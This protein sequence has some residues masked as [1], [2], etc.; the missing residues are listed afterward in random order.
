M[1]VAGGDNRDGLL[2]V[3]E[4]VTEQMVLAQQDAEQRELLAMLQAFARDRTGFLSFF[5]EADQ[6]VRDLVSGTADPGT[7]KRLVHTLK[8][9]A[10]MAS[11][12]VIVQLCHDAETEIES[13]SDQQALGIEALCTRWA[14]LADAFKALL[15]E[16]ARDTVWVQPQDLEELSEHVKGGLPG[17]QI[18][19]RLAAWHDEPV[20]LPLG[21]LAN[22]ARA[23]AGRLGKGDIAVDLA[24]SGLRLDPKRWGPLWSELVNVVRNA[25]DHG[26]ESPDERLLAGKSGVPRLRLEARAANDELTIE[27]EDN[28]RGI[29][30]EAI[31][32]SA[33]RRGMRAE[34]EH[35][36]L[37][38]LFSSG[39]SAREQASTVSGRGVG[40]DAV[41]TRV[42]QLAGRVELTSRQGEGTCWRF[43]FPLSQQA[44]VLAASA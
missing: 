44:P 40:M 8:G 3:I 9:N 36:L 30:W 17:A 22:Y 20:D 16:K 26:F 4:D 21:R 10:S 43:S 24:G 25:V 41:A 31:R 42:R 23:L 28:G 29:D 2:V 12:E 33:K 5:D 1:P 35:D 14:A 7:Q 15:G 11:L 27:V 32:R 34:T 19:Q 13:Q 37:T 18:I 6:I 38:A 39:V